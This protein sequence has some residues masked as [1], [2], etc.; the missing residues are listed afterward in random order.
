[1]RKVKILTS[2]TALGLEELINEFISDKPET[3]IG[4]QYQAFGSTS[5]M[6]F[7]V[8]IEYLEA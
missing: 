6:E 5:Y 4:I 8:L 7:T 1:M 2:S 3:I